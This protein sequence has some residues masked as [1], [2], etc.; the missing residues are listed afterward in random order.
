MVKYI[1][2]A[3]NNAS[4]EDELVNLYAETT[5]GK[6]VK[7]FENIPESIALDIWEAGFKTNQNKFFIEKERSKQV[8]E[9][10]RRTMHRK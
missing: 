6:W 8:R 3:N 7:I 4:N 9:L 10:N 5:D 1:N 2:A